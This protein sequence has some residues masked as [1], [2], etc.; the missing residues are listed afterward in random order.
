M[1]EKI[2]KEINGEEF[3]IG[4]TCSMAPCNLLKSGKVFKMFR[5]YSLD[6]LE[7][8]D[9]HFFECV[10]DKWIL[11]PDYSFVNLSG[12]QRLIDAYMNL[13]RGENIEFDT[14]VRLV[15]YALYS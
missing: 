13:P 9:I 11:V 7:E 3:T 2:T 8:G 4:Y 5:V 10:D 14:F 15:F 12:N 6:P 1:K